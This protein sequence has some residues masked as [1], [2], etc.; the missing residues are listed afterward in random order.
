MNILL[1]IFVLR[2]NDFIL[3]MGNMS[4][5][6]R[7]LYKTLLWKKIFFLL[8]ISKCPK[9]TKQSFETKIIP[10]DISILVNKL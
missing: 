7:Y 8:F 6:Y 2:F 5:E 3:I 1:N 4:F 9:S 10:N